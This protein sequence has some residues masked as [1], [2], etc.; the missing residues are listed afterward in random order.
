[1]TGDVNGSGS[2]D[3][4]DYAILKKYLLGATNLDSEAYNRTDVNGD[5]TVDIIDLALIKKYLL[6]AITSF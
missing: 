2:V 1:M 6:G 5:N 3:A 4:I